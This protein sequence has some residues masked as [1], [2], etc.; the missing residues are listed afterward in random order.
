MGR[1]GTQPAGCGHYTAAAA[2]AGGGTPRGGGDVRVPAVVLDA[3]TN[4]NI[5]ECSGQG[6][7]ST[8]ARV[9]FADPK[10]ATCR[11]ARSFEDSGMV[12]ARQSMPPRWPI[13]PPGNRITARH[14][15]DTPVL[16]VMICNAACGRGSYSSNKDRKMPHRCQIESSWRIT[17]KF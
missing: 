5:R 17:A 11:G 15:S 4:W 9:P 3:I 14:C 1:L 6:V 7:S 13:P 12:A 8:H 16:Q 2:I 10:A